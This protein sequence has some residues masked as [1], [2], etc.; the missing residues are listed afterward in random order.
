MRR[1]S[2]P[3]WASASAACLTL[4]LVA[5]LPAALA[6]Q[7]GPERVELE[8]F[9]ARLGAERHRGPVECI[10]QQLRTQAR[11]DSTGEALRRLQLGFAKL[12][13]IELGSGDA[14]PNG[15]F[16][17][18][19]ELRPSWVYAW[20]GRGRSKQ[21]EGDWLANDKLNLGM[22]VGFGAYEEAVRHYERALALEPAFT[23]ALRELATT[24][25]H[26][27]DTARVRRVLLPVLVKAGETDDTLLLEARL[28]AERSLGDPDS[29]VR[30][31]ARLVEL[32]G[33]TARALRELAASGFVAG[34]DD[35]ERH[36]YE[37][38]AQDDSAG[39]ASYRA[40][41]AFIADSAE[42]AA[43]DATRGAERATFLRKFWL[44]RD[45][46]ALRSEGTR[47]AE[48]YRRIA[49]AERRF[50][51]EVNRRYHH[52]W[53][54]YRSGSTRF[55]DRGI[56]YIR[57]GA[58]DDTASSVTFGLPP[59]L[60]WR[61]RRADGDL[62]LHFAANP[63]TYEYGTGGDLHDY[64]LV[65]SLWAIL[66]PAGQSG[67]NALE[68]LLEDRCNLY[69]PYCKYV[70]WAG[71]GRRSI[72]VD[73]QDLVASSVALATETDGHE[74][75][76]P[77]QLVGNAALFAVGSQGGKPLVHAVWQ[78]H[79]TRPS[80]AE[81]GTGLHTDARVRFALFDST[82]TSV[83]WIDTTVVL[84]TASDADSVVVPGRVAV[85]V[86]P[87]R[88]RYRLAIST[89][90][91]TGRVYPTDSVAPRPTDGRTL[92]V[93]DLILGRRDVSVPWVAAPGDT[94]FF[95]PGAKWKAEEE[96][97]A[98]H[99]IYGLAEGEPYKARLI[100][101]RGRRAVLTLGWEGEGTAGVTRVSRTLNLGRLN[102]GDYRMEL[103]VS[104]GRR[105]ASTVR[106]LTIRR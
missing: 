93:S 24:V 74:L 63:G 4:A 53:D 2:W 19:T 83:G 103:E 1:R 68:V 80:G 18:A 10:V 84:A 35:A 97:E 101:R 91:S 44:G 26:L 104:A 34:S 32:T 9:T 36:Y 96:L 39:V 47:L 105:K 95:T 52:A 31:A 58:P 28:Q 59:N 7:T 21:A 5:L 14:V 40:D 67:Q 99:E 33:R 69:E 75:R 43:F 62:L 42:L 8:R 71:Y 78:L 76:F 85:A 27:K 57:H 30:A 12:R 72:V 50:G 13:L 25:Q 56:V 16:S 11:R 22:R 100:V 3:G 92:V 106:P 70:A 73:E 77:R 46:A 81:S 49:E 102:P 64:R 90:D 38:A 55:D 23:P 98:Y 45:R 51:L 65:P 82:G 15:D 48:H 20:Y 6:G 89:D 54:A 37:G 86:P 87:G 29:A 41:L 61:Y 79:M 88:W 94:A 66:R 60:T 17:R